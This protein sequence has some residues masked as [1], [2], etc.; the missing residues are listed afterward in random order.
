[1][2]RDFVKKNWVTL[3]TPFIDK[4][5]NCLVGLVALEKYSRTFGRSLLLKVRTDRIRGYHIYNSFERITLISR[6]RT[7]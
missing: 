3:P 5:D 2:L 1:M 4:F 6:P 7:G